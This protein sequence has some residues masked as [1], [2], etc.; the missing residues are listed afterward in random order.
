MNTFNEQ[1]YN[2]LVLKISKQFK[3]VANFEFILFVIGINE[4]GQGLK[5]Y[6]KT[7]KMELI[8]LAQYALM[9]QLGLSRMTGKDAEGW[10]TYELTQTGQ[11]LPKDTEPVLKKAIIEYFKN[12]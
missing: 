8:K 7:E 9:A 5:P 3:V 4:L 6:S 11:E 1:E 2:E 10:P 12:Q